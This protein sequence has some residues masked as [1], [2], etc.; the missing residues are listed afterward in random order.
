[1][2]GAVLGDQHLVIRKR[3]LR[4]VESLTSTPEL[5]QTEGEAVRTPRQSGLVGGAVLCDQ[6]LTQFEGAL[7]G[8]QRL[9][10]VSHRGQVAGEVVH[11]PRQVG[12]VGGAVLLHQ[13]L[14]QL[15]RPPRRCQ[16]F[17][18]STVVGEPGAEPVDGCGDPV[19]VVAALVVSQR[20]AGQGDSEAGQ[21]P[22]RIRQL[23]VGRS[24]GLV[25]AAVA[26]VGG[27]EG[28]SG[29]EPAGGGQILV[30]RSG[31]GRADQAGQVV[32]EQPAQRRA[33]GGGIGAFTDQGCEGV[34]EVGVEVIADLGVVHSRRCEGTDQLG[35][36]G[37]VFGD[38]VG[39]DELVYQGGAARCGRQETDGDQIRLDRRD[40]LPLAGGQT[41]PQGLGCR[42]GV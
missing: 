30:G 39:G 4:G 31:H 23:P 17:G 36:V 6:F 38:G 2:G 28:Q 7:C 9:L 16:G 13:L 3:Q 14:V 11:V 35:P 26:V 41:P 5:A 32:G 29:G 12:Q 24:S 34:G 1:M 27:R 42:H 8:I 20:A 15:D 18:A 22:M 37:G 10:P 21:P 33:P 25:D 19:D 40:P